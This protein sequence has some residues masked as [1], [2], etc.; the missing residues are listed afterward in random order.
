MHIEKLN[1]I[2]IIFKNTMIK[3]INI[4]FKTY[5]YGKIIKNE[6]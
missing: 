5:I 4:Q 1:I 3:T 2:K 6:I